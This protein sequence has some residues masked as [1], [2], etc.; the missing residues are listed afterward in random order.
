M[1]LLVD[2]G[3]S[4]IKWAL[5][6]DWELKEF[7]DCD[8]RQA[9][10][11]PALFEGLAR[12]QAVYLASVATEAINRKFQNEVYARWGIETTILQSE[13]SCCGVHSGYDD[14]AQMGVDRWAALVAAHHQFDTAM[15]I[16]D[17]GSALTIDVLATDGSHRGGYILPGIKMQ[18]RALQRGAAGIALEGM[19]NNINGWG[20]NTASCIS[21]GVIEAMAALI[22]RTTKRFAEELHAKVDVVITG[23]DAAQLIP[24]LNVPTVYREH[25]V[26]EGIAILATAQER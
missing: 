12:P 19:E 14:A 16:V 6:Q 22:E 17:C 11:W 1:K 15:V 18:H 8:Y 9:S 21:L 20:T 3:N 26:L 13:K 7:G 23:G 4:R 10:S 25:L 2:I 24:S 5:S